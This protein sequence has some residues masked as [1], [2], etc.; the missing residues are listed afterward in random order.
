MW[1]VV[2]QW[3]MTTVLKV[4]EASGQS[5]FTVGHR[6]CL[7]N[8]EWVESSSIGMRQRLRRTAGIMSQ[9]SLRFQIEHLGCAEQ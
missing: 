1:N 8:G 3:K 9:S 6:A 5:G 2:Q 7:Q 4:R